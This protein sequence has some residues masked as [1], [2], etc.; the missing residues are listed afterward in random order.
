M[1]LFLPAFEDVPD[2][3]GRTVS[4][5]PANMVA[6]DDGLAIALG[7]MADNGARRQRHIGMDEQML[8]IRAADFTSSDIGDAPVLPDLLGQILPV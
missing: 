4:G 8:E 7:P 6:R 3:R 2:A 5:M 1:R